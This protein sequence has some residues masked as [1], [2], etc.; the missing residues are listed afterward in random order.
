MKKALFLVGGL[1]V[2]AV[3]LTGFATENASAAETEVAGHGT[4][5]ARGS[6]LAVVEGDGRVTVSSWGHGQVIVCGA[7]KIEARGDG[8]RVDL[9]GRC[10]QFIG[11]KGKIHAAGE[12]MKV[13]MEARSIAFS[14]EGE[15]RAF[16]KGIGSFKVGDVT[17]RWTK[18][19]VRVHY[20]S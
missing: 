9:P 16:L 12:D 4:L 10:V 7:E 2:A 13:T 19:G 17:G 3:A 18:D 6:G 5:Y 11:F 20:S 15:G 1:L 14:A 8:R